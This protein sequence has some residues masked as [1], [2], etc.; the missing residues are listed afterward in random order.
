MPINN[1]DPR[2][3]PLKFGI[4]LKIDITFGRI[5]SR[6]VMVSAHRF[7]HVVDVM[8]VLNFRSCC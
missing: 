5:E 1:G 4:F 8:D 2:W 6:M 7:S 3:P